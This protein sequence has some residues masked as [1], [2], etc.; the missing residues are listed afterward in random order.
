M[1]KARSS[2]S[3]RGRTVL[4]TGASSGIG[5]ETALAFAAAGSNV[6]LVARSAKALAQ[7]ATSARKLGAKAM[8]IPTDVTKGPAVAACFAKAARRFGSID[9]VV[10]NAG[11][12]IPAKVEDIRAADLK[13][14][15]DVNLFGALH[16]M[17]Q[18]VKVMR[19]QGRGHI[20][21]VASLAGRRGFS[22]LGGY[23]AT[24]FALVGM[25]EALRME[26]GG[27]DIHVS[28]VMPGVVDTPLAT[29]AQRDE[30]V[31]IPWPERL[32]MP[33]S[34]VTQCIFLAIRFRLAEIAVPPGSALIEKLAAL[35]PGTTDSVLRW[36]MGAALR[37]P[38]A[39]GT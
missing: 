12:M 38:G 6:A 11:V 2:F 4:V 3:F 20:V 17:Q 33:P 36:V 31:A 16:V 27:E 32:N 37:A 1:T 22:P 5:R 13:T 7:V 26:L 23:C 34:W 14:M 35:T 29:A 9:I 15:L 18:A 8:A 24:K 30:G 21:N 10:N 19:R 39:R 25:T 28:L